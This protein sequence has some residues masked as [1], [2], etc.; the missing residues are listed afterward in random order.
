MPSR[1]SAHLSD[2]GA[3]VIKELTERNRDREQALAVSREVIRFSA[4]AIRA[5]HRG[6]FDDAREL[7]GKGAT[8]LEEADHIS[9]TSPQIFNAGFMNDARKEFTEANVT[10]AVIS[11][12]DI[13]SI[14]DLKVD[15]AAYI[16]GLAE[17][18]GEL[19]RYILDALRR[20]TFDGCEEFMDIMDEM[21]SVLVTIDFPEGVTS[22]L[23]RNT[24]AMRGVLERTRGDLTMALRQHSLETRLTDWENNRAGS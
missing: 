23:R 3:A 15:A 9:Q 18:I 6:D 21:Y 7:I 8:R 12:A 11:G 16:N 20:D 10:L 24:D 13:P 1:Y 4:N 14:A 17:V 2:I 22:G 5:V 19:R